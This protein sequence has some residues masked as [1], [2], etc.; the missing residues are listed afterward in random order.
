MNTR[1]LEINKFSKRTACC[2]NSAIQKRIKFLASLDY[3]VKAFKETGFDQSSPIFTIILTIHDTNVKFVEESLYSVLNQTYSNTEIIIID[4]GTSGLVKKAIL[5]AF[6]SSLNSKA[7]LLTVKDNVYDP[8]VDDFSNQIVNLWN[9]GLFCSEGDFI[10]FLACDDKLTLNYSERMI[11]LFRGNSMCCSASPLVVSIDD[12]SD[13]IEARTD[14]L[15]VNNRREKYTSGVTLA[16]SYMDGGNMICFPGGVL[17]QETNLVYE[18]GGFDNQSDLSQLFKFAVNGECGFDSDALLFW[19]HHNGQTNKLQAKQGLVYYKSHM[20]HYVNHGIYQLHKK[21]AGKEFADKFQRYWYKSSSVV[22]VDSFRN[23][24][25]F[26]GLRSGYIALAN[27]FKE[28]TFKE[29][30]TSFCY[31]IIDSPVMVYNNF[32]PGD[33]KHLF[34]RIKYR[35]KCRILK[36][37]RQK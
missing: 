33:L 24:Y 28:C 31:V 16:N 30:F 36:L 8:T 26:F 37:K 15:R 7:K 3:S 13:V 35:V 18:C 34:R 12:N 23:S 6:F 11:D 10:Y 17:A 9:A 4:H 21:V 2:T 1:I 20:D 5:D 25:R 14:Y 27:I 22:A 19:R 32:I 29:L